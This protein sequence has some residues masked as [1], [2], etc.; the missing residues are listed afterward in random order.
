MNKFL[1]ASAVT[2]LLAGSTV[3]AQ[4]IN[5]DIFVTNTRSQPVLTLQI[6]SS[7]SSQWGPDI[8]GSGV[9][10][11]GQ[12]SFVNVVRD[13]GCR[14]DVRAVMASGEVRVYNRLNFCALTELRI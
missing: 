9:L 10:A 4:A 12:R 5:T 14:F 7:S 8:L 6:S 3:T 2:L 1:A 11:P 13:Q